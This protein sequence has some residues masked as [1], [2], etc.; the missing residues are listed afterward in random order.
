MKCI[1]TQWWCVF[2][3]FFCSACHEETS[4]EVLLKQK[5]FD[6]HLDE[7][8][9]AALQKKTGLGCKELLDTIE[10]IFQK[11]NK[12]LPHI[13]PC[14]TTLEEGN[15]AIDKALNFTT[16]FYIE[17]SASMLGYLNNNSEFRASL[18]ALSA[19]F[20]ERNQ[21]VFHHYIN[22]QIYAME[23]EAPSFIKALNIEQAKKYGNLNYSAL[24][25][26]LKKILDKVNNEKN[27][28]AIFASDF[29]YDVASENPANEQLNIEY[30]IRD[31]FASAAKLNQKSILVL[32]MQSNFS[33]TYFDYQDNKTHLENELRPYYIWLIG[34][35]KIIDYLQANFDFRTLKS[36]QDFYLFTNQNPI[37]NA[38][39]SILPNSTKEGKFKRDNTSASTNTVKEIK[40]L[41][42]DNQTKKISLKVA[43][44]LNKMPFEKSYLLDLK[45]YNIEMD[46]P[47]SLSKIEEINKSNINKNDYRFLAS[48]THI[49]TFQ[50]EDLP[51]KTL[52]IKINLLVNYPAW[53]QY[54]SL[55]DSNIKTQLNTTFGLAAIMYGIQ[56]AFK[57]STSTNKPYAVWALT[58]KP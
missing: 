15:I 37:N 21:A 49:L 32:R 56:A 58:I 33:G 5:T 53:E 27:T 10:A 42:L 3:A 25:E 18:L 9:I 20:K 7:K 57:N 31:I 26:M 50:I 43:L 41:Q 28:L 2:F 51:K 13:S 55:N 34:E 23:D 19:F 24:D 38:Y 30:K 1:F 14:K 29:I 44:D 22:E 47:N 35:H 4:F 45:N 39:A 46:L 6:Q 16:N 11:N 12:I 52:P 36:Y 8:E 17:N 54:S 40:Q 48:A